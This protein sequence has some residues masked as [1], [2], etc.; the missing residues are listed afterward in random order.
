MMIAITTL[1]HVREE[2][3]KVER[4]FV[5]QAAFQWCNFSVV[6]RAIRPGFFILDLT[7]FYSL[8]TIGAALSLQ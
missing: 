1:S 7:L 3:G 8:V 2:E 5:I 4:G 6:F